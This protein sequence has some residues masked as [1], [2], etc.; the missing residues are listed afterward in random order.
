MFRDIVLFQSVVFNTRVQDVLMS[1]IFNQIDLSVAITIIRKEAEFI[2]FY[3]T[4]CL[5]HNC[6]IFKNMV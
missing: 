3:M 4:I 6:Y 2:L 1:I 5:S